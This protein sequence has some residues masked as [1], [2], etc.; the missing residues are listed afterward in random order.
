MSWETKRTRLVQE[1]K[2]VKDLMKMLMLFNT[3]HCDEKSVT[4]ISKSLDMLPSKVSRMLGTME[5]DGFLERNHETNKYRLGI[6]FFELGLVY[7]FHFPLRRILR[8]HIEQMAQELNMT[9]SWGILR[10]NRVVVVDHVRSINIDLL[11]NRI[12]LVL[13]V[14]TTS[15]GKALLAYLTEEEQD[16]ILGS[17][18]L[19]KLTDASLVDRKLLRENLELVRERGYSTDEGETLA[20]LNCIAASVKDASGKVIAAINLT[21]EKAQTSPERLHQLAPY[22]KDKAL[23]VSRQLGY[24]PGV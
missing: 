14:Y 24:D 13:P 1:Y 10:D 15:I 8:P 7:A 22:V 20:D 2:T 16:R 23:F 6:M 5:K 21:G 9:A 12:G 11:T 17:I 18:N 3:F 19:R 4:E